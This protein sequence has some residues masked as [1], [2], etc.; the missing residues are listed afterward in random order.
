MEKI[1]DIFNA[2]KN[3]NAPQSL[4][5]E[6]LFEYA[7]EDALA[8]FE[9]PGFRPLPP[10]QKKL[11]RKVIAEWLLFLHV[12]GCERRELP[13]NYSVYLSCRPFSP[14]T[15]DLATLLELTGATASFPL[16]GKAGLPPKLVRLYLF[17]KQ[18]KTLPDQR[19]GLPRSAMRFHRHLL[20]YAMPEPITPFDGE[21]W[22]LAASL[23]EKAGE[24][25][26]VQLKRILAVG[27]IATGVTRDNGQVYR[28]DMGNK[29]ELTAKSRRWLLPK[30]N[31]PELSENC[32]PV[33][34]VN[35]AWKQI[36]GDLVQP[37]EIPLR[38]I[39]Q[40]HILV[41]E[42]ML[43][44]ISCA[45]QIQPQKIFLWATSKTKSVAEALKKLFTGLAFCD[46]VEWEVVPSDRM[47]VLYKKFKEVFRN[48]DSPSPDHQSFIALNATGGNRLMSWA[49]LYAAQHFKNRIQLVYRD[50]DDEPFEL[51]VLS[52]YQDQILNSKQYINRKIP[53]HLE[54]KIDWMKLFSAEWKREWEREHKRRLTADDISIENFFKNFSPAVSG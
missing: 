5:Q 10:Q 28:V 17:D 4:L 2:A 12:L 38:E 29:L 51:Q 49:A 27:W 3:A 45:L 15:P 30:E 21:S 13:K 26:D 41:G 53:A 8:T 50:I 23:A 43:P 46:S 11:C 33:A 18:K 6:R 31:N 44:I 19:N 1:R 40:L 24:Q 9:I 52:F 25:R 54:G 22:T 47:D 14:E 34:S 36:Q 39:E 16:A 37:T 48:V 7:P 42:S 20:Y 32:F 35:E